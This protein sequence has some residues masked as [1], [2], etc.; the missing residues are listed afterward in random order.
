MSITGGFNRKG[1]EIP[2]MKIGLRKSHRIQ[3]GMQW[4]LPSNLA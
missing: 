1:T 2:P 3:E 4:L